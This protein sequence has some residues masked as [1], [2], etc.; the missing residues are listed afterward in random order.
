MHIK[1]LAKKS[2]I[3]LMVVNV[4]VWGSPQCASQ[5]MKKMYKDIY[6]YIVASKLY[7]QF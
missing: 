7:H 6:I 3:F 2:R 4:R 5:K 1:R